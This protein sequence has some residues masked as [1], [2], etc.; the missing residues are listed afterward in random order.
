MRLSSPDRGISVSGE[1][2][3][4]VRLCL[5]GQGKGA[6]AEKATPFRAMSRLLE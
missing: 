4:G 3:K 1:S 5:P 6:E 2:E